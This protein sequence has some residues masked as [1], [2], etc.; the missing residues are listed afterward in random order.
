MTRTLPALCHLACLSHLG[1]ESLDCD[2]MRM[3]DAGIA[4][5]D[6]NEGHT[7]V[8]RWK[9]FCQQRHISPLRPLDPI[10]TPLHVKAAEVWLCLRFVYQLINHSLSPVSP[11]TG[12]AYLGTANSWH[13]RRC[14]VG[15][16]ADSSLAICGEMA[17]GLARFIHRPPRP[18]RYGLP[19]QALAMGMDLVL[20][21]TQ[22]VR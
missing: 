2:I 7:G 4:R 18:P 11:A 10:S 14:F 20:G 9:L 6:G 8:K 19:T 21:P 5:G 3:I 16:A 13:K 17:K 22:R 1:D 15:L 12:I